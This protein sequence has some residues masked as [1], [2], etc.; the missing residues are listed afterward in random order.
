MK[1]YSV[2]LLW[3]PD[4]PE[5]GPGVDSGTRR[6]IWRDAARVPVTGAR[7][8]VGLLDQR[9][10]WDRACFRVPRQCPESEVRFKR[11]TVILRG[12]KRSEAKS[13]DLWLPL[14]LLD[15]GF[16]VAPG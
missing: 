13:K 7:S 9:N 6:E 15:G 14:I 3:N 1:Q 12:A 16:I 2:C 11:S 4:V 8:K 5:R 10:A